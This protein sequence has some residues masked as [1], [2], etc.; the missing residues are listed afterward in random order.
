MADITVTKQPNEYELTHGKVIVSLYDLDGSANT[1]MSIVLKDSDNNEIGE[2]RQLPN[3][4]GYC[5]FDISSTLKNYV[6]S[7]VDLESI[8]KLSTGS[9][10]IFQYSFEYGYVPFNGTFVS[11]G[12][13]SNKYVIDGRKAHN[14]IDWDSDPYLPLIQLISSGPGG[15]QINNVNRPQ[16]ALTDYPFTETTG[17]A[18]TD[19]K[20]TWVGLSTI[21]NRIPFRRGNDHTLS[22]INDWIADPTVG[23]WTN[24]I[25]SFQYAIYNGDTLLTSGNLINLTSNGGGP[26][27][28]Y[29]AEIQPTGEYKLITTQSGY[30]NTQFNLSAYPEATHYYLAASTLTRDPAVVTQYGVQSEVYRFDLNDG[31]CNDF[32]NIEVSWLN[33]LG[34]RDYFDFQ[35]RSDKQINVTRKTYKQLDA[36]WNSNVLESNTYDR[37]ER[38][39]SQTINTEYTANTRYLSDIESQ[40]L[41]NLYMSPDVRVRFNGGDWVPVIL[42]S[43]TWTEKTF[44]KDRLFQHQI[45]FRLA[46][47]IISQNG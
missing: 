31:E 35:K 21:V 2:F 44:R 6:E 43:N 20:P 16:K 33:S 12:T 17:A 22:F 42:T 5:H 38:V 4:T 36:S 41:S 45:T 37:G 46:N 15:T 13:V 23:D 29:N 8:P 25:N 3:L 47:Q 32:D 34:G 19:G 9:N 28:V 26:N 11:Q 30:S 39:Y 24:G 40:Y 10:E 7:R 14:I 1:R 18:I 27:N